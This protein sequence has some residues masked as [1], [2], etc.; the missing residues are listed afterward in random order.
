[1]IDMKHKKS[2]STSPSQ[3]RMIKILQDAEIQLSQD[4]YS[5]LWKYYV[6]ITTYNAKYDLTR[7]TQ[8][9]DFIIKHFVDSIIIAKYLELPK[10]ILDIGTGA[11]FPGIPLKIAKPDIALILA[12][13]RSKRVE[14]LQLALSELG[15]QDVS[16]YPHAVTALSFFEVDGIITRALE[17]VHETLDR[18]SHFVPQNGKVIFMKGPSV[19]DERYPMELCG[20][21]LA[22]KKE[23]VLPNTS[24]KRCIL[25]YQKKSAALQKMYRI[26]KN[27]Q[28]NL[29]I[30]ITS[31]SN[32]RFKEWKKIVTEGAFKDLG[33]TM[34]S[35]KRL[36]KERILHDPDADVVIFDGYVEDNSNFI[37]YFENCTKKRRLYILKKSLF[38]ELDIFNTESVL[39]FT[40]IP[41]IPQWDG[42]CTD[43]CTLFVPFQDPSNVGS[44][45]RSAV[46]FN[47][48]KI[49]MLKG[50]AHPFHPRSVRA[51]A[52]VVFYAPL[53]YG[54]TMEEAASIAQCQTFL[55]DMG[56]IPLWDMK[57]PKNFCLLPGIEGPGIPRHMMN[58]KIS[59]PINNCVESLNVSVA[60]SIVLYAWQSKLAE[61]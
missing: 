8:F 9:D 49:V 61:A 23:Y 38:N 33:V 60:V 17:S 54:P 46:A 21:S 50:A 3:Q 19:E 36:V 35:G 40:R 32:K 7:I 11:G 24:H 53:F 6:L 27:Q 51:S 56:G 37:S 14:F 25:V 16:I 13:K 34:V 30:L 2:A 5:L 42:S 59:I 57:F 20:F 28:E 41:H 1:M 18:V 52:G 44:V 45:I 31:E 12:E 4:Q 10:K 15:L 43:G 47:V 55:I 29:E 22:E 58:E 48:S 26:F 39:L